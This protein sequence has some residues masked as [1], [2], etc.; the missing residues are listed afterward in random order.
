M[1]IFH[2]QVGH[3]FHFCFTLLFIDIAD[4]V[5]QCSSSYFQSSALAEGLKLLVKILKL[6]DDSPKDH[7]TVLC[8][9]VLLCGFSMLCWMVFC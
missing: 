8:G 7:L 6:A 3:T 2:L 9:Q 1:K 5:L 4:L